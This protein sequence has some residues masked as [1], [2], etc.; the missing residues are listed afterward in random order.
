MR[1]EVKEHNLSFHRVIIKNLTNSCGLFKAKALLTSHCTPKLDLTNIFQILM[2]KF[3]SYRIIGGLSYFEN[4]HI[5]CK[6]AY[7]QYKVCLNES[8]K[9]RCQQ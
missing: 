4:L 2:T 1:D 8:G 5:I 9:E 3:K 7:Y 6:V